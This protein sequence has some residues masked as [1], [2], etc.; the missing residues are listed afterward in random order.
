VSL[1]VVIP[2]VSTNASD[3][4]VGVWHVQPGETVAR[5]QTLLDVS[6]DK[7]AFDVE[8]PVDGTLLATYAPSRS[9]VPIG[10][11]VA[12]IGAP[13]ETDSAIDADNDA[14]IDAHRNAL[15]AREPGAD[16]AAAAPLVAP[17]SSGPSPVSPS[18]AP[19]LGASG[20]GAAP[21]DGVRATPKAKRLARERGL[22]LVRIQAETGAAI[23]TEALLAPYL[24]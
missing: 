21:S 6:T 18:S 2:L 22:D 13:G 19:L 3:V 23:I 5:G 16:A 7:A 20:G 24:S 1:R 9:V 8:V 17:A 11:I 14:V 10:Y 15:T 4:T 12:L